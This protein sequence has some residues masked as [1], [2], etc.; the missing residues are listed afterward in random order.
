MRPLAL[1]LNLTLLCALVS[2]RTARIEPAMSF[3]EARDVVLGMQ[4][5]PMVPPPRKIEDILTLLERRPDTGNDPLDALIRQA[6][7]TP[8]GGLAPRDRYHFYKSRA[9]ARYA[10]SR[11][12]KSR[13]DIR[14][15]IENDR[16]AGVGDGS[17]K[18]RL[19]EL[20]MAAGRYDSAMRLT[21]E[22]ASIQKLTKWRL[23]PYRALKS[24]IYQRMG[25]FPR[26]E[27]TIRAAKIAYARI[28]KRSRLSLIVDGGT[29]DM[30]NENDILAA[31]AELLEAQ[32]H[33]DQAHPLRARVFNYHYS[34]RRQK[35]G[36]SIH[37]QMAM[38]NN[39]KGQGRLI[40]A[41]REAR[42]AVKEAVTVSGRDSSIAAAAVQSLAEI[43]LAKGDLENAAILSSAL[44]DIL[45]RLG[46]S[47]DEDIMV[48]ARLLAARVRV[49]G[50][51][52]PQAMA[53]FDLALKGM[54]GNPYFLKRYAYGNQ[55]LILSLIEND[56]VAEAQGMMARIRRTNRT[57]G[58]TDAPETSTL[59]A[60]EAAALKKQRQTAAALEKF[61]AAL[62]GP[63]G[64]RP[65][66]GR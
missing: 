26:A 57:S 18:Q 45:S 11:L 43:L 9:Q 22:A 13:E 10:L 37:A 60:L 12:K 20:E 39:L 50:Q 24:R 32:G 33:Y 1:F 53:D 54:A 2:C 41:E 7:A 63:G 49:A 31:E 56:R 42:D 27:E 65:K 3:E 28:P 16:E 48:R 29:L 66:S 47:N 58:P 17:L 6:E 64:H 30:G 15:A 25:N 44:L 19:A 8:P 55:G 61:A 21:R 62:P 36:N 40:L 46:L 34:K 35:P 38:A 51:R 14:K 59:L 23:G 5:V 52:F 4:S